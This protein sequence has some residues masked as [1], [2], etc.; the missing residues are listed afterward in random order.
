[1]EFT[2]IESHTNSKKLI[3]V[4]YKLQEKIYLVS[5]NVYILIRKI[6]VNYFLKKNRRYPKLDVSIE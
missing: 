1:M 5:K 3:K 6:T 2:F 4:L